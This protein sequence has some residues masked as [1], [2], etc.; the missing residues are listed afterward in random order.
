MSE[1]EDMDGAGAG[2]SL[3]GSMYDLGIV[4]GNEA[5]L[6]PADPLNRKKKGPTSSCVMSK[7]ITKKQLEELESDASRLQTAANIANEEA[8]EA[9]ADVEA[10]RRILAK[11]EATAEELEAVAIRE[12]AVAREARDVADTARRQADGKREAQKKTDIIA[13]L[14]AKAEAAGRPVLVYF[15]TP[16]KNAPVPDGVAL[17]IFSAADKNDTETLT[18]LCEQWA[19]NASAIDGFRS[20]KYPR[21]ETALGRAARNGN[22][23]AVKL[24]LR[25]H[26]E[27]NSED[28]DR[29]TALMVAACLHHQAIAQLLIDHGCDVH[30]YDNSGRQE[31]F[32]DDA[33]NDKRAIDL[34]EGNVAIVAM[35]QE[36]YEVWQS[37]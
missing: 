19:G 15:A 8:E 21:K 3:F 9:R 11:L 2:D 16:N 18:P 7:P 36:A 34:A 25:A 27:I 1:R 13:K 35:I 6:R 22:I 29:R 26:A 32:W 5:P 14:R 31:S 33:T 12:G 20:D 23:E 30:H 10:A 17:Q 28:D 24:L 37:R 4:A